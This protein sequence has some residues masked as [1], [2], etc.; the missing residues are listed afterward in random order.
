MTTAGLLRVL[1]RQRYLVLLGALLTL[2]G[3]YRA[4]TSPGEY[5]TSA[6]VYFV[7]PQILNDG[8]AYVVDGAVVTVA[9]IVV[10]AV[11]GRAVRA[12]L[13]AAGVQEHYTLELYNA[14]SQFVVIYDRP[15]LQ[16]SVR[17]ADEQSVRRAV[18]LI[19]SRVDA[20]LAQRQR[21]V[22]AGPRTLV[23][24]QLTPA[25]P[26]VYHG[27]GS[28]P[29]ALLGVLLLGGTITLTLAVLVDDARRRRAGHTALT[30]V[31]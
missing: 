29:R 19:R 7:A 23:R 5:V 14:G 21:E 27:T 2:L 12:E 3:G 22:G 28:R 9:D 15:L 8:N 4:A 1:A 24:T 25:D 10:T 26:P 30:P 18:T 13:R 6:G 16:L 31:G 20:E 11:N 17:G